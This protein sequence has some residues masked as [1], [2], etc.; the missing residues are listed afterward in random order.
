MIG[1]YTLAIFG[2]GIAFIFINGVVF[3]LC[4][5]GTAMVPCIA[6]AGSEM[7]LIEGRQTTKG[8]RSASSDCVVGV[9]V[10]AFNRSIDSDNG[11][12]GEWL[13]LGVDWSLCRVGRSSTLLGR[14]SGRTGP[15]VSAPNANPTP[16]RRLTVSRNCRSGIADAGPVRHRVPGQ[17]AC[18]SPTPAGGGMPCTKQ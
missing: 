12:S 10:L 5:L 13:G 6:V 15:S 18:G 7:G 4:F 9:R 3:A 14:L 1:L 2:V 16:P 8:W 17:R 11:P